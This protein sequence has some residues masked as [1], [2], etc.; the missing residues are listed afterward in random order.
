M[1]LVILILFAFNFKSEHCLFSAFLFFLLLLFLLLSILF[2][3]LSLLFVNLLNAYDSAQIEAKL[4]TKTFTFLHSFSDC[5]LVSFW[6][7]FLIKSITYSAFHS[8][9]CK[10]IPGFVNILSTKYP[11]FSTLLTMIVISWVTV[12][13]TFIQL[14]THEYRWF[15]DDLVSWFNSELA[16]VNYFFAF[17]FLLCIVVTEIFCERWYLFNSGCGW[18]DGTGETG[19]FGLNLQCDFNIIFVLLIFIVNKKDESGIRFLLFSWYDWAYHKKK[20]KHRK[21]TILHLNSI[22][23]IFTKIFKL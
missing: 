10:V 9:F 17:S 14:F 1:F 19:I 2:F 5:L 3:T 4:F 16:S 18:I 6:L 15:S 20:E 8:K 12:K 21:D 11:I 22:N 13:P 23:Y 7:L